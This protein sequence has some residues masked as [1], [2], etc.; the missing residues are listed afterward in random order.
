M[1]KIKTKPHFSRNTSLHLPWRRILVPI[2][3]SE[4]SLRALDV[5]VPLARD[6]GANLL[7]VSAVEPASYA[8]GLETML[9]TTPGATLLRN[10]KAALLKLARRSVPSGV[11]ANILAARGRAHDVIP[12]VAKQKHI[13]L[14][15]LTTHGRTGLERVLLGSTAERVVRHAPCPVFVVRSGS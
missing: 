11:S 15:V 7:L 14:I 5:A 9:L 1:G 12:R 3:F 10:T 8:A 13:D 2:D 4:N 6:C